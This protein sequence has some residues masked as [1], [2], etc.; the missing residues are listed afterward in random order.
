MQNHLDL[1]VCKN[2]TKPSLTTILMSILGIGQSLSAWGNVIN[3]LYTGKHVP[4]RDSNLTRLLMDALGGNC[5]TRFLMTSG[6]STVSLVSVFFSKFGIA[7]SL[8]RL[9]RTTQ[10]EIFDLELG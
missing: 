2:L 7:V 10:S 4:Y 9:P 5:F 1:Q 8:F 6:L 3:A